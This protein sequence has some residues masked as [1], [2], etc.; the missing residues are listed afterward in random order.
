MN[1][2]KEHCKKWKTLFSKFDF[3][4]C[5]F[6][7]SFEKCPHWFRVETKSNDTSFLILP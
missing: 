1:D 7:T 4:N 3:K 2:E 6:Y 5:K